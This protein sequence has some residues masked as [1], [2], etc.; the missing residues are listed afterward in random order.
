MKSYENIY[1]F[2]G[3]TEKYFNIFLYLMNY[4]FF[5][6]IQNQKHKLTFKDVEIITNTIW[7]N[8]TNMRYT[9]YSNI[10]KW[11]QR[12]KSIFDMQSMKLLP[13]FGIAWK[14]FVYVINSKI[15]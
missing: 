11:K 5:L 10:L 9:Q 4:Y 2:L 15:I 14:L 3:K 6:A 8:E 13:I 1:T 7:A 12:D